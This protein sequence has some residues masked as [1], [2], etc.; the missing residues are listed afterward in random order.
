MASIR[1]P[2][3]AL[4]PLLPLVALG[5]VPWAAQGCSSTPPNAF[6]DPDASTSD[7]PIFGGDAG[8]TGIPACASGVYEGKQAPAAMLVLLQ[9]SGSMSAN[10][11]WVFAAQAIV[12]ALDQPIFDTMTLGLMSAPSGDVA[13][14]A[15]LNGLIPTVACAV[16]PFPQVDLAVAGPNLSTAPGVRKDIKTW[17]T[18]HVPDSSAGDGNPLYSA[19]QAGIGV[20][21]GWPTVGKRL[22]FVVTDGA[23]SCTSVSARTT[24]YV[25]GNGCKD[26]ENPNAIMSLLSAANQDPQKPIETFVVGVPGAD[27]YDPSGAANP[28]YRMRAALSSIAKAG[29]PNNVPAACNATSP[30][31]QTDPNPATSCHFDMTQ[32]NFSAQAVADAIGLVRGKVLGCIFE[33]P[34]PDGGVV[35]TG[36]VNVSES[37]NGGAANELYK[38]KTTANDCK[39]DGCW[40]YTSDGKVEL[41]GKACDDLKASPTGKVTITVGCATRVN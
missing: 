35:D 21:N 5:L 3:L 31:A 10:N 22:L 20:L 33:L 9:R 25:D 4:L 37:V 29:S 36:K 34:T 38:R 40:D 14:P 27:S 32:N 28:P 7:A 15:C 18:A 23:I 13:A 1:L 16:P 19:M 12:Q 26:W 41:L 11:K 30:F 24:G 8:D 2:R 17:L 6:V 39:T